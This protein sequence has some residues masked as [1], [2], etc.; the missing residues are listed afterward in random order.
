MTELLQANAMLVAINIR[1]AGFTRKDRKVTDQVNRDHAASAN[2][3]KYDKH[4][5]DP[6]MVEGP[7]RVARAARGDHERLTLP[8]DGSYRLLPVELFDKYVETMEGHK[9]RFNEAVSDL[10]DKLP[11]LV[12]QRRKQLNGMFNEADYEQY[13]N[14]ESLYDFKK[15]VRDVPTGSNFYAKIVDD[16]AAVIRAEIDEENANLLRNATEHSFQ[17]LYKCVKHVADCL[18][19]FEAVKVRKAGGKNK[20]ETSRRLYDTMLS[21]LSDLVEIL[22]ALNVA[23]DAQLAALVDEIR[24]SELL[25]HD[26]ET[27]KDPAS[28]AVVE[29]VQT[30]AE[31]ISE[32]LAGFFGG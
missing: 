17:S 9:S 21:N 5:L 16:Q 14:L 7:Q 2:A 22:P 6:R 12:E 13:R 24:D 11:T 18:K 23:G 8:W 26:V 10:A 30:Q 15:S 1:C 19:G 29:T 25:K 3:G 27:F 20:V 28:K 4:L 32:R 31:D